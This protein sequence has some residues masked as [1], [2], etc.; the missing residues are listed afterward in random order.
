[1][2]GNIPSPEEYFGYAPGSDRMMTHWQELLGYYRLLASRSD[3]MKLVEVG[4]STEGNDFILLFISERENLE[5]LERYREIS[6]KMADPR[7]LSAEEI[8]A[9][10]SEGRAVCMQ[11][12]GLHSNEVGGPLAAPY[13]LYDLI[14][15]EGGELKRILDNVIFI[16]SPC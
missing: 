12:Y 1:M 2:F 4:K 10:A 9:L 8:D 3:R 6:C 11:G 14:T 15:A 7:G 16:M 13:I 5:N